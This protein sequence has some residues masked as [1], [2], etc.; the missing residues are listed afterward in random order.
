MHD[1]MVYEHECKVGVRKGGQLGP[2]GPIG[3]AKVLEK[4]RRGRSML[5]HYAHDMAGSQMA[6]K[7]VVEGVSSCQADVKDCN[8][9]VSSCLHKP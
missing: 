2:G 1:S 5:L 9:V 8:P 3:I 6:F 7:A 4:R